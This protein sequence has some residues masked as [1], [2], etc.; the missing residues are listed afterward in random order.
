MEDGFF[1][2]GKNPYFYAIFE[3]VYLILVKKGIPR[4]SGPKNLIFRLV[5]KLTNFFLAMDLQ[6]VTKC[7]IPTVVNAGHGKMT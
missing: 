2:Y 3:N 1:S 6:G 4:K 7:R 5:N